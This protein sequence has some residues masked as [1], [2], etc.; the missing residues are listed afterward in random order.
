MSRGGFLS[1]VVCA[2]SVCQGGRVL[3][4]NAAGE[5]TMTRIHS[6]NSVLMAGALVA[7]TGAH[8]DWTA[9]HSYDQ[10]KDE[11]RCV[12]ESDR[13]RIHDGYRET[14]LYLRVDKD[15][16]LVVTD[17]H[18]DTRVADGGISVD[19]AAPMPPDEVYRDQNAFFRKHAAKLIQQFESGRRAEVRLRFWPTWPTQ[20]RKTATFS[21]RGFRKAFARLPGC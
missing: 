20:G 8:A 3:F 10:V 15:S 2:A 12:A 4:R 5:S 17:S 7:A 19:G 21:L 16:V 13:L 18:I 11:N 14:E 1:R 6:T 9:S